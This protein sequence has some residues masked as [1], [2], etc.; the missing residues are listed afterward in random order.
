MASNQAPPIHSEQ[1]PKRVDF[2]AP[3]TVV[4]IIIVIFAVVAQVLNATH[5]AFLSTT[6]MV[7]VW[8]VAIG[9]IALLW[10]AYMISRA[11]VTAHAEKNETE[12]ARTAAAEAE[13]LRDQALAAKDTA[14]L[15]A[16][17]AKEQAEQARTAAAEAERLR[18]QALAAKD[19]AK[20][21]AEAAKEQAEAAKAQADQARTAAAEAESLR[22][23]ALAAKDTAGQMAGVAEV[24]TQSG[25]PEQDGHA[26]VPPNEF[27]HLDGTAPQVTTKQVFPHGCHL[28]S[29]EPGDDEFAHKPVYRCTVADEDHVYDGKAQTTMVTIVTGPNMNG[30]PPHPSVEFENLTV[31]PYEIDQDP[32]RIGY[33]LR[34]DKVDLAEAA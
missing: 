34:A 13:R 22:D 25:S 4:S 16:G 17:A 19:T 28:Q 30:W 9:L 31:T 29:I 7:T 23:Q 21:E 18:D 2:L 8:L 12:Q 26:W 15:E 3:A 33:M 14:K 24:P 6:Q 32:I 11:Y 10:I 1:R 27:R 20:L 5:T